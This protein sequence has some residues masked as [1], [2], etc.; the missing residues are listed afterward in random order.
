MRLSPLSS[1][2]TSLAVIS[3]SVYVLYQMIFIKII[4]LRQGTQAYKAYFVYCVA[5]VKKESR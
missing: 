4:V 5:S 1:S 3:L 2:T